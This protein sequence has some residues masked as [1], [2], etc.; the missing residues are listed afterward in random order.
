MQ[1]DE[2][3]TRVQSRAQLTTPAEAERVTQTVLGVLGERLYR[4][5]CDHLAA[6]LPKEMKGFLYNAQPPENT[7]RD[8]QQ[9]DLPEFYHRVGAR[10]K[11]GN[12]AALRQS[13]AVMAVVQE[14]VS[15]GII[16]NVLAELPAA[17]NELFAQT[18]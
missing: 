12:P 13:Q 3:L 6:Q 7:W 1:Y 5:V 4:T 15:P 17:F 2:F 18:A 11:I 10:L 9:F 14:A 16:E 8:V